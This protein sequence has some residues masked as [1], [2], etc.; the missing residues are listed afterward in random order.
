[1]QKLVKIE[2]IDVKSVKQIG[3]SCAD[4]VKSIMAGNLFISIAFA[5]ALQYL[6]GMVNSLQI[7][8]LGVLY[9]VLLP[10]NL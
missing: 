4:S 8:V 1:M 3:S 2:Y 10:D 5:G 6:W 9:G 7:M